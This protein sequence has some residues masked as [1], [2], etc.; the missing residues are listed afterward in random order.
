LK[1]CACKLI[2]LAA[3][4]VMMMSFFIEMDV[5]LKFSGKETKLEA[6]GH[7]AKNEPGKVGYLLLL[8]EKDKGQKNS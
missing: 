7:F 5:V 2:E 1:D 8:R 3:T 6:M 4:A